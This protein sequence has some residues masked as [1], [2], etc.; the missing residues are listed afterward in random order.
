MK[1]SELDEKID[2]YYRKIKALPEKG[3]DCPLESELAK[4]ASGELDSESL[5]G[6][7]RHV[8]QCAY[9]SEL[10]EG[11]LLYSAHRDNIKLDRIPTAFKDKVKA[12]NPNCQPK[13]RKIMHSIKRNIW[14]VLFGSSI[15]A[16]FFVNFFSQVPRIILSEDSKH[17]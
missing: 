4:Y 16:S 8:K 3:E 7:G 10:L 9:C 6:I 14:G 17:P 15:L 1:D 11:A 2:S 5:Y 12:L 13:E